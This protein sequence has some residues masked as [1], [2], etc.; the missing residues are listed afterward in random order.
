[1]SKNE[2]KKLEFT[3]QDRVLVIGSSGAIGSAVVK[4]LKT[5][6]K[7]DKIFTISRQNE[8]FDIFQ[9]STIAKA[10]LNYSGPFRLI[11][12]ATGGLE[13]DEVQPEKTFKVLEPENMLKHYTLNAIG[14]A[15][16]IKSFFKM[17]PKDGV[18]I[19]ASLS[20]R[21]GSIQDNRL[22]GWVSYRASKAAL[23][24]IIKTAS[25][26]I[27][28]SYPESICVAL[29]PGTVKSALTEK[30][31]NTHDYVLPEIAAKNLMNVLTGLTP[32]NSGGFFDYLGRPIPW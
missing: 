24:Q 15:L 18:S 1:M 21:V 6:L 31:L 20:A 32:E 22:G 5:K 12:D 27:A 14:P 11:F 25:I 17:L 29:H 3:D 26:E 2:I 10:A 9:P 23:N 8:G 16:I 4:V 19:F 7:K 13:I 30:Y 28:R